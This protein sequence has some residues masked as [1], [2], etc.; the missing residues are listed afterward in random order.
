MPAKTQSSER[1]ARQNRIDEMCVDAL[2]SA[3]VDTPLCNM[4]RL[5]HIPAPRVLVPELRFK[6]LLRTLVQTL[7]E[8][9]R[10]MIVDDSGTRFDGLRECVPSSPQSLF[11]STQR[12]GS[13][14]Y[15]D[16]SFHVIL[17]EPCMASVCRSEVVLDACQRVL[18]PGGSLLWASPKLGTFSAFFDIFE[19][20]I[21][22][23]APQR[24]TDL[25]TIIDAAL[26]DTSIP[27]ILSQSGFDLVE[28]RHSEFSLKFE[29]TEQLLF[30]TIVETH[31]LG[32]CLCLGYPDID[33]RKLLTQL[34]RS[35]HHY[36]Q[37]LPFEVPIKMA[38][39]H[40][41]K[42]DV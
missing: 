24:V 21:A 20:C 42:K 41:V 40:A 36:F 14:N 33:G 11:F 38:L 7:P 22:T 35:F 28:T 19:E 5:E 39:C 16:N 27:E 2:W 31:Y 6:S 25:R 34:V 26:D 8:T 15:A 23:I 17:T 32:F 3:H 18:K 4:I 29:T 1:I 13:L 37:G 12:I 9:A 30:S 10:L